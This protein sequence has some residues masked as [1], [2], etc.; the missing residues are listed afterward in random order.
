[1]AFGFFSR[2]L[3]FISPSKYWF[4]HNRAEC[5]QLVRG[6]RGWFGTVGD[7]TEG[8]C[9]LR[10]VGYGME[11]LTPKRQPTLLFYSDGEQLSKP[12]PVDCWC[13]VASSACFGITYWTYET[14]L[15]QACWGWQQI[16][17]GRMGTT[18]SASR[19]WASAAA[20]KDGCA[21]WTVWP[22]GS[23]C[24]ACLVLVISWLFLMWIISGAN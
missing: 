8:R 5:E 7:D 22:T 13:E 12:S 21:G 4:W 11:E 1:M 20:V 6:I 9:M 15:W 18:S 14:L 24:C 23:V 10:V 16:A 19:H 17:I 3:V 2:S